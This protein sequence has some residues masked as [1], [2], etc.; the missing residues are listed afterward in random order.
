MKE[1]VVVAN[2]TRKQLLDELAAV[3]SRLYELEG[4]NDP[5][6]R[7]EDPRPVQES[8]FAHLSRDAAHRES[9]L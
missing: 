1:A 7:V 2:K 4:S 3:Q 9:A 5:L 6:N 8:H